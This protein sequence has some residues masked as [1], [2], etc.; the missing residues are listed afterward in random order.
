MAQRQ[1]PSCGSLSCGGTARQLLQAP[2]QCSPCS[3]CY[4]A[5]AVHLGSDRCAQI[6][7][8]LVHARREGNKQKSGRESKA[9]IAC[10]SHSVICGTWSPS[11]CSHFSQGLLRQLVLLPGADATPRM[12]HGLNFKVATLSVPSILQDVPAKA[13]SNEVLKYPYG[14]CTGSAGLLHLWQEGAGNEAGAEGRRVFLFPALSMCVNV[15]V[16]GSL[17]K[18]PLNRQGGPA[19]L[20]GLMSVAPHRLS[21][22]VA[23]QICT[24]IPF[25]PLPDEDESRMFAPPASVCAERLLP[26]SS[27]VGG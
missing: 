11:L 16:L 20:P 2:C 26:G 8:A 15:C 18:I 5:P 6:P 19:W 24:G 9:W 23:F 21:Q 22:S 25:S 4:I 13:V 7:L 14:Q 17:S 10:S 27:P 1:S 12:C 3:S